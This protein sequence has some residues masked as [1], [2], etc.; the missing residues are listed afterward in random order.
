MLIYMALIETEEG[1]VLFEQIYYKYK[2][3]MFHVAYGVLGQREDAEDAV[4]MAFEAIAKNI[5]KISSVDCPKT[6]GYIVIITERKAIDIQRKNS[7]SISTAFED[8]ELGIEISLPG[9]GGLQDAI[10]QLKPSYREVILLHF[11][12][13]YKTNEIAEMLEMKQ[14]ADR[15]KIWRAKK[16]LEEKLK[17]GGT[18]YEH[19]SDG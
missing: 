16:M 9:D 18:P 2:G 15:K 1:R 7:R 4:Q 5:E 8:W 12:Y 10:T 17:E 13:G 11:A 3:L 19:V 14:D 6:R